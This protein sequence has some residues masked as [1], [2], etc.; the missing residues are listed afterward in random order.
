VERPE[1]PRTLRAIPWAC[2]SK[3]PSAS[4]QPAKSVMR[5]RRR[6]LVSEDGHRSGREVV[7]SRQVHRPPSQE[8]GK[9]RLEAGEGTCERLMTERLSKPDAHRLDPP[10]GASARL[11]V[12]VLTFAGCPHAQ[13]A[14]DLVTRIVSQRGNEADVIRLDVHDAAE[15]HGLCFLGSPS[16]RIDGRDVEPGAAERTDYSY[17]CRVYRTSHGQSGLPSD[18]WISGPPRRPFAATRTLIASD[19]RWRMLSWRGARR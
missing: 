17:G 18:D 3:R 19:P 10:S 14:V 5:M 1:T 7:V 6:L 12:E 4:P 13:L 9:R 2:D 8:S 16:I 15:A 11:R